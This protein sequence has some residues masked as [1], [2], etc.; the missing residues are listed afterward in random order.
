MRK[1]S[2]TYSGA[3]DDKDGGIPLIYRPLNFI[4]VVTL[5]KQL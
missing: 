2:T 4:S 3:I 5:Q 1:E